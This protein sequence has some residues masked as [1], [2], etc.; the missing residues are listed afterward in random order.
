MPRWRSFCA[1]KHYFPCSTGIR[2]VSAPYP[3]I[4]KTCFVHRACT[5]KRLTFTIARAIIPNR[6]RVSMIL[7]LITNQQQK[8]EGKI[9]SRH[10]VPF[11]KVIEIDMATFFPQCCCF[12]NQSCHLRGSLYL[13][14][15]THSHSLLSSYRRRTSTYSCPWEWDLMTILDNIITYR[16][17]R[18]VSSQRN[19]SKYAGRQKTKKLPGQYS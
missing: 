17:A 3:R 10:G 6:Y 13:K 4:R 19:K 5:A 18:I 11:P 12:W 1:W 8:K 16:N 14:A 7:A 15:L 2:I 9:K